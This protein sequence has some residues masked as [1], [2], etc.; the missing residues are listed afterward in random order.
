MRWSDIPF[1]P[2]VRTLRQFGG[3]GILFCFGLA[4]WQQL[5]C[6]HT[7][8][9][10]VIAGVG[11]VLG[12]LGLVRPGLLRPLF[13]GAMVLTFP[14]GWVV[15]QVL[16]AVMFYGVF[17]PLSLL[18][19]AMGRDALQRWKPEGVETYWTPKPAAA[20]VHRYLNQF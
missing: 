9:A 6:H 7:V 15:S 13:V 5:I 11:L 17:A 1:H 18:F 16:L 14:I 4:C 12:T 2:P 10:E 3:L 8:T 20:G 19:R